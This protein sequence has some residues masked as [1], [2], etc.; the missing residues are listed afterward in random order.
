MSR[1]VIDGDSLIFCYALHT[2]KS[3]VIGDHSGIILA[4]AHFC[5]ILFR[6]SIDLFT[7]QATNSPRWEEKIP[8]GLFRGRDSRKER[9]DLAKLAREGKNAELIDVGITRF[10]FFPK[11]ESIQSDRIDFF[12]FF[13]VINF[14]L[15]CRKHSIL[16][17]L[18]PYVIKIL[19]LSLEKT[20]C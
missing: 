9:L 15:Q 11:D 2:S 3:I 20:N 18:G 17:W 12:D 16:R 10:F 13:K 4:L 1:T 14:R 8:K 19:L 7:V 5:G 6:V